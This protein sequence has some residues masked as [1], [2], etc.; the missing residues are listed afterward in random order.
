MK[1]RILFTIVLLSVIFASCE[2]GCVPE[3]PFV[4]LYLKNASTH[5]VVVENKCISAIDL[6]PG[7]TSSVNYGSY[8]NAPLPKEGYF[9]RVYVYSDTATFTFDDGTVWKHYYTT[10]TT[11]S[12]YMESFVPIER[13]IW[14]YSS[15]KTT[16]ERNY[17]YTITD[18]DYQRALEQSKTLKANLS[19]NIT[20]AQIDELLDNYNGLGF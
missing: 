13:N 16:D 15:W 14:K 7:Q 4:G 20:A 6:I 19:D 17:T 12:P 8:L 1:N 2:P 18:E 5:R 10:D 11:V 3:G 9:G